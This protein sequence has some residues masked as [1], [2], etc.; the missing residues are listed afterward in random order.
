VRARPAKINVHAPSNSGLLSPP[1]KGSEEL[2]RLGIAAGGTV[3]EVPLGGEVVGTVEVDGLAGVVVE[4]GA[5]VEVVVAGMDVVV[6]HGPSQQFSWHGGTVV[7]VGATVVVV[8]GGAVV[9]VS[10]GAVVVVVA[11]TVVV[12]V[13]GS[14][15]VVVG[16]SVVVV[17]GASVVVVV[18][19]AS[20][21]LKLSM[22]ADF[23]SWPV[24]C[25]VT[26]SGA[27]NVGVSYSMF[28]VLPNV[29]LLPDESW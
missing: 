23:V 3:D 7:V 12:V 9:V 10:G 15:L 28:F 29:P 2:G 1:V 19:G 13:G 6:S 4:V 17:V 20:Q 11:S 21:S 26:I 5:T 16:A 14:V 24:Q 8:S 22:V 27:E 25:T 18:G